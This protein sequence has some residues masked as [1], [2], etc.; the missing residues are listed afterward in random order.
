MTTDMG[1]SYSLGNR[2]CCETSI[3]RC[4]GQLCKYFTWRIMQA[5]ISVGPYR[6]SIKLHYQ[7]YRIYRHRKYISFYG[8]NFIFA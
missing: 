2:F 4:F 7:V 1:S 6:R 3:D 8:N 5:N